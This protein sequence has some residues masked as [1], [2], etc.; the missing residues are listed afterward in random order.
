MIMSIN[1]IHFSDSH[2]GFSD[3]DIQNGDGTN[4]REQDFY[5]S[6]HFIVDRIIEEK[7]SFAVHTGDFFHR[8]SPGNKTIVFALEQIRR[9]SDAGIPFYIIAGNHDYPKSVFTI[10]IHN[11]FNGLPGVKVFLGEEYETLHTDEYIIH[12]LPHI[13]EENRFK[14]ECSKIAVTDNSKPNFLFMHLSVGRSYLMDEFG[15]RIF[16]SDL[17]PVLKDFSYVGLGHWHKYQHL[18]QYG[19]VYYAGSTERVSDKEADRKGYVSVNIKEEAV[20]K[21]NE[22]PSRTF[23]KIEVEDCSK[24]QKEEVINQLIRFADNNLALLNGSIVCVQ[25][26]GLDPSQ[27]YFISSKEI[28]EIFAG[29]LHINISR[30][31][32]DSG[33]VLLTSASSFDLKEQL[34]EEL[35]KCF[36]KDDE[37]KQVRELAMSLLSELEEEEADANQ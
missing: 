18:R 27:L 26:S 31:V 30:S 37:F 3:L 4:I 28:S 8:A 1:F 2:L 16:P 5:N 7:P 13:N 11:I 20:V 19:S 24:R 17:L 10:P 14:T 32:K 33:E 22:T 36:V 34:N 21:F 12:A 6:F 15:E 23:L 29:A 9:I 25:L 35:K